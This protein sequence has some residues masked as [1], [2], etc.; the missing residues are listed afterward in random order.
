MTSAG[1]LGW[2]VGIA[3]TMGEGMMRSSW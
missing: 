1:S 3:L 2:Q